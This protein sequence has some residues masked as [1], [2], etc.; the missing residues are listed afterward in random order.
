MKRIAAHRTAVLLGLLVVLAPA[1][2][3][4]TAPAPAS[5][6]PAPS[7]IE[8][9]IDREWNALEPTIEQY[10]QVHSQLRTSQ[11]QQKK[12]AATL[13]P[14]Q[15]QVDAAMSKVGAMAAS[16]YMQGGPSRVGTLLMS[17]SAN[18]LTDKLTFL[19]EL[20]RHQRESVSEVTVLRDRYAA[21]KKELDTLTE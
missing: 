19:N 10:N 9:Q 18:N 20:A 11:A 12:L 5:A 2:V 3:V 4:A 1:G 17:G 21:D 8:A 16:A 6:E 13:A 14:L 15:K 7:A